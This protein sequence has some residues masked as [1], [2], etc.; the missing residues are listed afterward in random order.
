MNKLLK[1]ATLMAA[2]ISAKD[3]ELVE[4]KESQ[5]TTKTLMT[6]EVS[7]SNTKMIYTYRTVQEKYSDETNK[8][9][10]EATMTLKDLNTANFAEGAGD[11]IRM[12]VGW[13]NP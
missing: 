7:G 13:R 5:D 8:Y 9:Y 12:S 11:S 2:S 10:L 6:D 4:I 3:V 1:I